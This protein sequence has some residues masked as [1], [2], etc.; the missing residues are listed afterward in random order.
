M[1]QAEK[2]FVVSSAPTSDTSK[3]NVETNICFRNHGNYTREQDDI[4]KIRLK[5]SLNRKI[6]QAV[7]NKNVTR[8]EKQKRGR[9]SEKTND[10]IKEIVYMRIY[11]EERWKPTPFKD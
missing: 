3:T 1:P 4:L 7:V 5:R 10:K 2:F 8:R 11:T 9:L 6:N